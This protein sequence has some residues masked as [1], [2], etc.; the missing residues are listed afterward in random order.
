M[1]SNAAFASSP[2]EGRGRYRCDRGLLHA[3]P[4][5]LDPF[6]QSETLRFSLFA[7]ASA[8]VQAQL[9]FLQQTETY[10]AG[11]LRRRAFGR[12]FSGIRR[13]SVTGRARRILKPLDVFGTQFRPVDIQR[14]LVQL[15]GESEWR[16]VVVIVDR[17][18]GVGPD[19]ERL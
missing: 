1:C 9:D 8:L 17:R 6:E 11:D 19:I 12:S 10:I 4:D 7:A 2:G 5:E 14:D 16:A 13:G 15:T 3:L 18:A